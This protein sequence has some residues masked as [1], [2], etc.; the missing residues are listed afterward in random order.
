[1]FVMSLF[2]VVGNGV[3]IEKK[4]FGDNK[5]VAWDVL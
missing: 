1:M 5:F 2:N 3:M 4:I